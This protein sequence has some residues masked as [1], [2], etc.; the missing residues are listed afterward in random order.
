MDDRAVTRPSHDSRTLDGTGSQRATGG[1]VPDSPAIREELRMLHERYIRA[2]NEA[3]GADRPDEAQRLADRYPDEALDLL[4][5][6]EEG[7]P[8]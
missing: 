4:L 2:V 1:T 6:L 3:I 7:R 8:A 5:T